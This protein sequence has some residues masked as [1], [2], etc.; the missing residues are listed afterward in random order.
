V[1][2]ESPRAYRAACPNCG[3][4]VEFASAASASAVCSFCRSTLVRDG[5]AL[6]RIGAVAELFDDHSPLQLGAAGRL[7]GVPFTLVGRLQYGYA[8]GT[9]NEWHVLFEGGEGGEGGRTGWL[10]EDNGAY[11]FAF[12][13]P[14]AEAAPPFEAL[15]AG[16]PLLLAGQR[17]DVASVVRAKLLS[18]EG[19]LPRPPKLDA[20]FGVADLRNAQGEVG[21]LDYAQAPPAWSIGRSVALS[22]LALTNLREV[23]EKT[24]KARGVE[25]P[26][27]GTALEVK[28]A[29]TQSI[30][31][32]HCSAVVD[33][34][35]GIGGELAHYAQ[36][37][38]GPGGLQPQI[39]LGRIGT[40]ALGGAALP[41]Q[42][43]GFLERCNIADS[44]ADDDETTYWREYLLWNANAGFA[45][46]VDA[47]DGWSWVRP[48]T[49]APH[50]DGGIAR[51]QGVNYR[52]VE[53]YAAKVTWVQ[54]E[55]YWRVQRDERAQVTDYV[56]T[57]TTS[58]KRLSREQTGNEV[59]CSVGE[60]LAAET[61]ARA[62]AITPAAAPALL[63]DA[64]PRFG[65]LRGTAIVLGLFIVIAVIMVVFEQ[66]S[67]R[68]ACA[69]LLSTFGAQSREY[70]QCLDNDGGGAGVRSSGGSYGGWS[71]GGGHK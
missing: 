68:A 46:L 59:T 32:T 14:L 50:F 11:V 29:T 6:R 22:E 21:T 37:N 62:F 42:A 52:R 19:E 49:G 8:D 65:G 3:A 63:R 45:F 9:W 36:N 56:G 60:T 34:S 43:V 4:P 38:S 47:E 31:C 67:R 35:K 33:L 70:R 18:A 12:D 13:T 58:K 61:I 10:S 64:G 44:G 48:V 30:T 25:C 71:S 51:W 16:A 15:R 39:P 27:C 24:L 55:F 20:E 26:N 5:D 54:G 57:G 1:A 7:Q 28:L 66:R 40:I 41:W 69:G 17:W 23:G 53:T 2:T